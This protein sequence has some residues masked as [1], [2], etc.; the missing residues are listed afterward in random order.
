M[1]GAV[2]GMPFFPLKS[3]PSIY[4]AKMLL[5][6]D[7]SFLFLA[8]P[9]NKK[10]VINVYTTGTRMGMPE[11]FWQGPRPNL[12]VYTY[13]ATESASASHIRNGDHDKNGL[14]FAVVIYILFVESS[15]FGSLLK[16]SYICRTL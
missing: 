10:N 8:G 5:D 16:E 7:L 9:P 1:G 11:S 4:G 12:F 15:Y 2:S 14:L 6:L 13:R 3:P